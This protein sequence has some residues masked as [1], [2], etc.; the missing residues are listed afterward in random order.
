ML[1]LPIYNYTTHIYLKLKLIKYSW[2]VDGGNCVKYNYDTQN[3]SLGV[4]HFH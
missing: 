2:V 1:I 3:L 4:G